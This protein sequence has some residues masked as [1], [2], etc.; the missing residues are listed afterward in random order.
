M[1]THTLA[2][3]VGSNFDQIAHPPILSERSERCC[4]YP[5]NQAC[6]EIHQRKEEE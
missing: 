2:A 5:K 6:V 3:K 1:T 4:S